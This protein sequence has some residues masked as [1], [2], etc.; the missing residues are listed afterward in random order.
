MTTLLVGFDSAWTATNSG[1]LVGLLRTDDGRYLEFGNPQIAN[2]REAQ[3]RIVEWQRLQRPD[4]TIVLLDQPTIVKNGIGQRPVENIVGS[5]VSRR[6]GGMQPAN[7]GKKDMFGKDAPVWSFLDRFGGPACPFEPLT[8][9]WVVE[10]Y[11]VLAMIA[12][13]WTLKDSRPSGRLPKYN[14]AR[15]RTFSISDWQHVCLK[16]LDEFREREVPGIVKW[17]DGIA[18]SRNPFKSDQDGLDACLC[19][20][21]ALYLVESRQCLMVG[22]L[23]TGFIVVPYGKNLSDELEARC[24]QTGLLSQEWVQTF[25]LLVTQGAAGRAVPKLQQADGNA[26]LLS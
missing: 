7:T 15:K 23:D 6:Y 11:P 4:S 10:T 14:P 17:L 8:G 1:A 20:L 2:F 21:A 3:H 25:S 24:R 26:T 22:D 13:E 9:T 19:L 16:T 18:Q 5:P 12:L